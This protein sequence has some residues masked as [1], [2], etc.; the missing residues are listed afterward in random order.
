MPEKWLMDGQ[1][2]AENH[3]LAVEVRGKA[4]DADTGTASEAAP[5]KRR[6]GRPKGAV[7]KTNR[8]AKEAIAEAQ[9]ERVLIRI[10]RGERFM[11]AAEAGAKRKVACYPTLAEST[12][13]AR[14]LLAKVCPDVKAI[15]V[16]GIPEGDPINIGPPLDDRELGRRVALILSRADRPGAASAT[17]KP[18]Q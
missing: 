1:K 8:L 3:G 4:P 16:G 14:T 18:E 15:E 17:R 10:M 6:P 12:Q 13:A 11:R 2:V 9:P 7:N 5:P